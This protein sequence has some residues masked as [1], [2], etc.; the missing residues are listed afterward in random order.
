MSVSQVSVSLSGVEAGVAG[1]VAAAPVGGGRGPG[2]DQ[3]GPVSIWVHATAGGAACPGCRDWCTAVRD[4]Y[5]RRL[6]DA[7]AGG[8]RVLVWLVVRLL[9]R[10]PGVPEGQLR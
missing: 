8:R 3:R 9:R 7:A 1:G 5:V 4:R 10:Q 6:R 2:R